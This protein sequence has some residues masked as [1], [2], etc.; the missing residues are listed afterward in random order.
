MLSVG[1]GPG[2]GKVHNPD[3]TCLGRTATP[4]T[5]IDRQ[6]TT[7]NAR[8][9]G[10]PS[11]QSQT[12]RGRVWVIRQL[13]YQHRP[14]QD[15]DVRLD[16]SCLGHWIS[17]SRSQCTADYTSQTPSISLDPQ[18]PRVRDHHLRRLTQV[19]ARR[20]SIRNENEKTEEF[21]GKRRTDGEHRY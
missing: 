15:F 9:E 5:H 16:R 2:W 4:L 13:L 12:G 8:F 11:W 21:E 10:S 7:P 18:T 20:D 1:R 6:S 3:T 17:P 14:G 19:P